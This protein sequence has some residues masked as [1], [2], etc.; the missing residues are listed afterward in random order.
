MGNHLIKEELNTL[1]KRGKSNQE[2]V[3]FTKNKIYNAVII[4]L[5]EH[6]YSETSVNRI[7]EIAGVSRGALTHH[8]PSKEEMIAQTLEKI[9]TLNKDNKSKN[10]KYDLIKTKGF[11]INLQRIWKKVIDTVEGRALVEILIAS[12][13]D[14]KL[15]NRIQPELHKFNVEINKEFCVLYSSIKNSK[16]EIIVLWTICRTFLRGL[17]IQINFEDEKFN[18]D[19]VMKKFI[20]IMKP[21]FN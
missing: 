13:T 8:F 12:R 6:G 14:R 4:S 20:E 10:E 21:F 17:H 2:R 3:I 15:K 18:P 9:L 7:Q 1:F 19:P 5:D 16:E 11:E